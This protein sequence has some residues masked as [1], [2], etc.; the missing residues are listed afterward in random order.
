MIYMEIANSINVSLFSYTF[1]Y[2]MN[3][4]CIY[5]FSHGLTSFAN[6]PLHLFKS[7]SH[8]ANDLIN[9][10]NKT[11]PLFLSLLSLPLSAYLENIL[12][13]EKYKPH[14]FTTKVLFIFI[15]IY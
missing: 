12:E 13:S 5:N 8:L 15:N 4:R 10:T 7:S 11:R 9:N 6:V 3:Q 2:F 14:T 1:G